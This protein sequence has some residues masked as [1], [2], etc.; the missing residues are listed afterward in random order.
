MHPGGARGSARLRASGIMVPLLCGAR[1]GTRPSYVA[2]D[3]RWPAGT[4]G[5]VRAGATGPGSTCGFWA[6]GRPRERLW[7][8]EQGWEHLNMAPPETCAESHPVNG[9]PW[10]RFL[11]FQ[12][13]PLLIRLLL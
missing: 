3:I 1:K 12:S 10:H 6:V 11:D 5:S 4:D 2:D 13:M 9:T 7:H 8:G